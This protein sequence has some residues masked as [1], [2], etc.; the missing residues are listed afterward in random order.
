MSSEPNSSNDESPK[1]QPWS[2][3]HPAYLE[4]ELEMAQ[5]GAR[6]IPLRM[7]KLRAAVREDMKNVLEKIS[8]EAADNENIAWLVDGGTR[9]EIRN[10]VARALEFLRFDLSNTSEDEEAVDSFDHGRKLVL[11]LAVD[12]VNGSSLTPVP[13]HAC[14][15]A[16]VAA[17]RVQEAYDLARFAGALKCIFELVSEFKTIELIDSS[18]KSVS[19]VKN[20]TKYL[21]QYKILKT[22]Q[23][24]LLNDELPTKRKL[25]G[26]TFGLDQAP[27]ECVASPSVVSSEFSRRL[28]EM[29][30]AKLLPDEPRCAKQLATGTAYKLIPI[31][32]RASIGASASSVATSSQK[33]L[34]WDEPIYPYSGTARLTAI[35]SL[36]VTKRD[37]IYRLAG[38]KCCLLARRDGRYQLLPG[39]ARVSSRQQTSAEERESYFNRDLTRIKEALGLVYDAILLTIQMAEPTTPDELDHLV[40]EM[41]LIGLELGWVRKQ[42]RM[43]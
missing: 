27:R 29:K 23:Q 22:L 38:F 30:I 19:A 13:I 34:T 28:R 42:Q 8:E 14:M 37:G 21:H 33:L 40:E 4:S 35:Q 17:G 5:A 2:R 31:A 15:I 25:C 36:L 3:N 16:L 1:I 6:V 10:R 18:Q 41:G 9:S 32:P 43:R 39:T 26:A 20:I 7:T 11:D 24:F 12:T